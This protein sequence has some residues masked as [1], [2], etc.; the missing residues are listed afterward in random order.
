MKIPVGMDR[1]A[2]IDVAFQD[3][4][5]PTFECIGDNYFV[6]IS[7]LT[8]A[9]ISLIYPGYTKQRLGNEIGFFDNLQTITVPILKDHVL[10]EK[11]VF[12]SY[13]G[14][15]TVCFEDGKFVLK[16]VEEYLQYLG[17]DYSEIELEF[18]KYYRSLEEK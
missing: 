13:L 16:T 12:V 6:R 3:Q 15:E 10:M 2:Y 17:F 8:D 4:Y 1:A 7:S 11:C 14:L 18:L 9:E 5:K